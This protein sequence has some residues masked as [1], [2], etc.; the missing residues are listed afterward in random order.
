ML[1]LHIGIVWAAAALGRYPDDVL[2]RIL[3]VT[4]LTVDAILRVDLQSRI[5][6]IVVTDDFVYTGRA[7]AL[8]RRV[9]ERKV[10]VDRYGFILQGQVDRLSF[11]MVSP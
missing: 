6:A 4:R 7:V 5:A 9:V 11:L 1:G 2:G 8:F 10:R 3:D